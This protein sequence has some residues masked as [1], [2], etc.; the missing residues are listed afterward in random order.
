MKIVSR[1]STRNYARFSMMPGN[2]EFSEAK[3]RDLSERIKAHNLL[4]AF[5]ILCVAVDGELK[6]ID[7]QHR[8]AAAKALGV[9]IHYTV[10]KDLTTDDVRLINGGQHPWQTRDYLRH[11]CEIGRKDYAQVASF[12]A[13]SKIGLMTAAVMLS[14]GTTTSGEATRRFRAGSFKVSNMDRAVCVA[15]IVAK[16]RELGASFASGRACVLALSRILATGRFSR[17]VFDR[18]A[19]RIASRIHR[20]AT[21]QQFAKEFSDAYDYHRPLGERADLYEHVM[22]VERTKESARNK[23]RK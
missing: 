10:A 9:E 11:F 3:V 8:L 19:A 12:S 17:E 21:W 2:R 13:E 15:G 23:A 6:V 7:G 18:G 1:G 16:L 4:A 20:C 5:P 14:N 22:A